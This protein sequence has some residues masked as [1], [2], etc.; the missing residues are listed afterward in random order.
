MENP[1][2]LLTIRKI[3]QALP[4]VEEYI[5]FHTPAF[6]VKNRL[7]ARLKEDGETL[8][9]H[10]D[11]RDIWMA[12]DTKA[13]FVTN[14]YRNYPMVLARLAVVKHHDLENVLLEAWKQIAPRRLLSEY[15]RN[16]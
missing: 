9:I 4:G 16:H 5:C 14:H 13:F 3:L 11:D 2:Y 1:Q 15:E 7:L 10:C 6:R 8:A 12:A